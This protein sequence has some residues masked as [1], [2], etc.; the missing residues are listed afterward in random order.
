MQILDILAEENQLWETSNQN[1]RMHLLKFLC[2]S[3]VKWLHQAS[4]G[5]K[6][7]KS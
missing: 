3:Q 4:E 1:D 5:D 7:V 2:L 6:E